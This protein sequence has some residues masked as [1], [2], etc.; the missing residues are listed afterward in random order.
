MERKSFLSRMSGDST[1]TFVGFVLTCGVLLLTLW[2]TDRNTHRLADANGAVDH[3]HRVITG[4]EQL[5]STLK[6]AE[7]G[8]RGFVITG[9]ADFLQPY[10]E[11]VGRVWGEFEELQRLTS[12]NP[13]QQDRLTLLRQ[14]IV[15]KLAELKEV[16]DLRRTDVEAA[17]AVVRSG[18]S[19]AEMDAVRRIVAELQ[20]EERRLLAERGNR[21]SGVLRQSVVV[22]FLTAAVG[23]FMI[24][25]VFYLVRRNEHLRRRAAEVLAEH[26]ERL[27][28]TLASIG[29]G[30]IS[31]DAN[32]NVTYLN[33]VAESLTG[34]TNDEAAGVA[35]TQ[36]FRIV[37]EST[38]QEVENPAMRA[39]KEGAIVGLANHT[40]LIAKDGTERPI[41]DSAAPIRCAGGELVGCVLVF[42]DISERHKAEEVLRQREERFRRT[43]NEIAIPTLLHADDDQILLVNK[44]WTDITGYRIEDI[45]TIGEWTQRAYGER[46]ATVKEF[47]DK[48]FEADERLD[49][50]EWVVTTATGEKRVWQ[51]FSTPVGREPSGRRLLV[52]NAIDVTDRK[53]AEADQ[54]DAQRQLA[55]TLESVTDGFMR[56]D[57]DWRIVYVNAEAE[58]INQ[59]TRSEMLGKTAWELFPAVVG[60]KLDAEYRRAVAEQ[61]TVEFE[62][63]YEPWGRW[64]ALKGYPTPD[65]GLTTFVRDVTER[66]AQEAALRA[67]EDRLRL[68]L[69]A[70]G[71][72]TWHVDPATRATTTDARF[73]AIFGTAEERTD[74]LQLFAVMHPDD[75]PAVRDAVATATRT[76]DPV[77]Y[78]I[79]YRVVH[80]DG[81]VRWVFA[82]GRTNYEEGP[83]GRVAVSFDGTVADVTDQKRAEQQ[84]VRLAAES[85]RDRRLYDTIL[86][87]NTDF[88]FIFD[89]GGRFVYANRATLEL[90]G[91]TAER[92][93]GKTM[94]ELDYPEDVQ[95]QMLGNLRRVAESRQPVKDEVAY[96]SPT[97]T[98]G[99]YE[100][101]LVPV[102]DDGGA[103]AQ[104]VGS[105]RNILERKR[106][107]VALKASE[108]R[109][110]RLF[111][112]AK[113]GILILDAQSATI[114][115]A[116]PFIAEMLGY[117]Q[118]EL[119]GKELWQ[120]G[121][122]K[123]VEASKAAMRELQEKRYIRYEDLPLETK[124]GRRI[125]VEF[126]SNVYG[127]AGESV[128]QCNIR[129]ITDRKRLEAS[130][131]QHAAEL[132]EADR[133]KDEFLAT[134]AHEL[135]NPLAPIRNGLQIMRLSGG[136]GKV[137]QART[138]MERQLTQLVR[139]VDDLLDVSRITRGKM[140]LRRERVELRSVIDAAVEDAR[141]LIEQAGHELVVAPSDEPIFVDGD[142]TRL[143]QVVAN[144]LNNSAKYTHRGGHVRLAV[145]R[146]G[147]MVAVSVTDDGIGI[148]PAMLGRVFEMFTQVD[149]N[150]E[151]TT[152]GLGIGLSLVKGLVEMHGG[153]IEAR[154]EGEGRGSEFVVRLP[155]VTSVAGEPDSVDGAAGGAVP[156]GSRRILVVDDNEDA[157]DSLGQ[158]LEMLGNDVRTAHD[159]KAGVEQAKSFRP[160]VV[161]MDIGMPKL[162]GYE[163]ARRI[164]EQ[165]WGKSMVLVALT[166]WGQEDDRR[167]STDAGFDFH[168]VKPVETAALMKLLAGIKTAAT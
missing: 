137:E 104:V 83:A 87:A 121:L 71:L 38:R 107:E 4:L 125:N 12:D 33:A 120:I 126:V 50:G 142:V 86:S 5:L 95:T 13:A 3:T 110:R 40:C 74:Y 75:L 88:N 116:N 39:L 118:A 27:R 34:W 44:A 58:R 76:D 119:K 102:F 91:T 62:N 146:E 115:D 145:G 162:N 47:I 108:V 28:T 152:G 85:D 160:D 139:L 23:V 117:S 105:S 144:L 159:G 78:A 61:V 163:A 99:Y 134:L 46:H 18:R 124:A 65:G 100:Y 140:E 57:R 29:D 54:Q 73:R 19:K 136:D 156:S 64:Y 42:R 51:F 67:S 52:S 30:V 106:A 69:D 7:T 113:D 131:R 11:A 15:V 68:A 132:S 84:I 93:F 37:N 151:K 161:L 72:G 66:K 2:L 55:T 8:Q 143:A 109:Y 70:A 10:D 101:V 96:T 127:E 123:D 135:R 97:G 16:I 133:R 59:L 60:T 165:P 112:S 164:R 130:L 36:V 90:W 21:T 45:P 168:L 43:V 80:P 141:P 89:L 79:E 22:G 129:D 153:T 158:L 20:D 49:N 56:Y 17:R 128:I 103:V 14:R 32:G 1:A 155:I 41:D 150:L 114:T 148:P 81:S 111:E 48:L 24:G 25:T 157:A 138:M 31:T 53:R 63:Y 77:P 92:A 98:D 35:L 94:A 9:N 82:K 26:K 6:D 154:S 166:G 147:G 122:F 149:R 167:K